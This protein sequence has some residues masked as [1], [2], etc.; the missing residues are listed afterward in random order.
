MLLDK[1]LNFFKK[2][3]E[4]K[5]PTAKQYLSQ[6]TLDY[7]DLTPVM[8]S[9]IFREANT[10]HILRQADMFEW[11]VEK[12]GHIAGERSKRVTAMQSVDFFLTKSGS[13][14]VD[15]FVSEVLKNL[16]V[17]RHLST[18]QDAVCKG[19][20]CLELYW[21]NSKTKTIPVQFKYLPQKQ[22]TF[23]GDEGYMLKYP[24]LITDDDQHGLVIPPYKLVFHQHDDEI[25][26][27]SR[28]GLFRL[29]S[30]YFLIKHYST[31]DWATYNEI[32][33]MPLRLGKYGA[34]ATQIDIDNLVSGLKNLGSD[35]S[36]VI[37]EQTEI[38]FVSAIKTLSGTNI[39][40]ELS[41]FC[42]SEI[43]KA[44]IGSAQSSDTK[45]AG[46]YASDKAKNEVREDLIQADSYAIGKTITEQII[47]PVVGFNFGWDAPIPEYQPMWEASKDYLKMS[48]WMTE[49]LKTGVHI[50]HDYIL[51]S[52]NIPKAEGDVVAAKDIFKADMAD[53]LASK[54]EA[55]SAAANDQFI[56]HVKALVLASNSIEEVFEKINFGELKPYAD[57]L[58]KGI[59]A[60]NLAGR[61]SIMK[62][63]F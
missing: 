18:L 44:L 51:E 54:L 34:G 48:K 39:Y 6:R 49:L 23:V 15:D 17:E 42:N 58:E 36:A 46:S 53:R 57:I 12:D 7:V 14:K 3:L 22:F 63:M 56:D 52:F 37:S 24:R 10:G 11:L 9:N 50:P 55:D 27:P 62:E 60:A 21:H 28:S 61:Y 31:K 5:T 1:F 20:V 59:M 40:R 38:E 8:L 32:F 45:N 26:Y 33:G 4:Q 16:K 35:A 19:F 13:Q 2:G 41:D 43:S 47:R 25:N 29:C 30:I